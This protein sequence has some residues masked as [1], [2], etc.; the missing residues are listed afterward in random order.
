MKKFIFYVLPFVNGE[1][2]GSLVQKKGWPRVGDS[3]RGV[4]VNY[5]SEEKGRSNIK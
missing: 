2:L 5:K 1:K 3:G 4:I